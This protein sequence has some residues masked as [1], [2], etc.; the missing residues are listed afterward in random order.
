MK[1]S[2]LFVIVAAALSLGACV[3]PEYG[4]FY[5]SQAAPS[6]FG[7]YLAARQAQYDGDTEA[8]ARLYRRALLSGETPEP[9][10]LERAYVLD[11]SNGHVERAA[12]LA[13]MALL[14]DPDNAF[15]R[16]TVA[17]EQM[18][19]SNYRLALEN[20]EGLE[21]GPLTT[22][23]GTLMRAWAM[24]G[25]GDIDGARTFLAS[26]DMVEGAELFQSYHGALLA[27]LQGEDG[28]AEI[29]YIAAITGSG[30]S[31]VRIIESFG[32]FLERRNRGDE[33][34]R[35]YDAF[36]ELA[37]QN[38]TILAARVRASRG[39]RVAA[40]VPDANAGGAE[41]LFSVASVIAG[42]IT[43]DVPILYLRLG[44]H[45]RPELAEARTLLAELYAEAG[46][47]EQA[48][49]EFALVPAAS[50]LRARADLRRALLLNQTDRQDEGIAIL[51]RLSRNQESSFEAWIT[52]GDAL[53]YESRFEEAVEA[54]S[55]AVA[56]VEEEGPHHWVLYYAYGIALERSG[57]WPE[58][59]ATLQHALALQPEHP[60]VLN[61][62][63]YS[64]I[65]Q[66]VNLD[67]AI[68]MIHRAVD[69]RPQDG[70][71]IDSLG[72][73]YYQLGQYD[74]AI[75]YLELAAELEPGDPTLNDHLGDA[76]WRAGMERQ[77]QFQWNHALAMEPTEEQRDALTRKLAEGLGDRPITAQTD[78]GI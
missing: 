42:E 66:G 26:S 10:I 27:D 73:G 69:Q 55:Q 68:Q 41:A 17:V 30:G 32:R 2:R 15:A 45:L 74:L 40:L 18:S 47:Q 57:L 37:P 71:I 53:R 46:L 29:G 22:L 5:E 75:E 24:A 20:L 61:Y 35:I 25:A 48:V 77:A 49:G 14:L 58:A 51:T 62:L 52:L 21:S 12:P 6:H 3:T 11:V 19:R 56:L 64:W 60:Y 7:N 1:F 28:A 72:W 9:E 59:E 50:P 76:Y 33:A 16:L 4:P 67:E 23:S 63:G 39:G 31:S 34:V 70:L 78:D 44:L 38:P 54:Y 13:A 8:A 36:L 43:F 65:E